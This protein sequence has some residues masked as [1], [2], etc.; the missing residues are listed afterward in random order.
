VTT[1][2]AGTVTVKTGKVPPVTITMPYQAAQVL[3]RLVGNAP[4][5]DGTDDIYAALDAALN[6]EE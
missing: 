2:S 4:A 1:Y 5:G 6:D 3:L